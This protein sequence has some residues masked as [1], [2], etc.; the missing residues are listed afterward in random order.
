MRIAVHQVGPFFDAYF[1]GREEELRLINS[2]KGIKRLALEQRSALEFVGFMN[3][4]TE[5]IA[6]ACYLWAASKSPYV[7][8]FDPPNA[9]PS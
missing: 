8:A 2:V 9:A 4:R 7:E 3:A 1:K 5:E 6:A